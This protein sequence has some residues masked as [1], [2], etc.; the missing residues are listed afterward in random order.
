MFFVYVR[1]FHA[2]VMWGSGGVH[3]GHGVRGV[4]MRWSWAQVAGVCGV[5]FCGVTSYEYILLYTEYNTHIYHHIHAS[6]VRR[7]RGAIKLPKM[8]GTLKSS[9]GE[10]SCNTIW[11]KQF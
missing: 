10:A 3:D 4:S 7:K 9:G 1:V 5:A 8:S 6:V 11:D 2:H